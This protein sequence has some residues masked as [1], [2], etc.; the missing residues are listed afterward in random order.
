MLVHPSLVD[1]RR[2]EW[3]GAEG[4]NEPVTMAPRWLIEALIAG[5]ENGQAKP[6]ELPETL[7]EGARDQTLYRMACAFRR[8]RAEFPDVLARLVDY[9]AKHCVPPLGRAL[10][11]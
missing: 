1:G 11:F 2:Y 10:S 9:D 7:E 8:A 3:D 5:R 6:V 4:E